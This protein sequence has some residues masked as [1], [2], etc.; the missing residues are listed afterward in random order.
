MLDKIEIFERRC[1]ERSAS[2]PEKE[3]INETSIASK[4]TW[5]DDENDGHIVI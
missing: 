5:R 2:R 4:Q 3:K 1:R